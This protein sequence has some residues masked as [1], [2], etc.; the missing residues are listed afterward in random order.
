MLNQRQYANRI[1]IQVLKGLY[2]SIDCNLHNSQPDSLIQTRNNG[3][4]SIIIKQNNIC[5]LLFFVQVI[6]FQLL[7]EIFTEIHNSESCEG[8]IRV[9]NR[10]NNIIFQHDVFEVG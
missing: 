10:V 6:H 2:L 8:F 3:N 5:N 1:K 7:A 9:M 4:I